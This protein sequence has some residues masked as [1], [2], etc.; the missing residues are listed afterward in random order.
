MVSL[1][2]AG[3]GDPELLTLRA[4]KRL[5]RADVILFDALVDARVLALAPRARC[6]D[7][8]KRAGARQVAQATIERLLIRWARRGLRVVRLKGGDPFVFGRGGEEALALARAGV[9]FEVV[10][11]ISS[12]IA[13]PGLCGIPLT[14]RGLS[15]ALLVMSGHDLAQAAR[16]I[17]ALPAE[18]ATLVILMGREHRVELARLLLR[19]GFPARAPAA[20]IQSASLPQQRLWSGDLSQLAEAALGRELD[21]HAPSVLVIGATVGVARALAAALPQA[22]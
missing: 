17:E 10:P 4:L 18:G 11:G 5:Q 19:R 20:V 14:H 2:G 3:P 12:A 22:A 15:S 1:I 9:P 7:V 13:A 16:L 21:P 6:I 8:G